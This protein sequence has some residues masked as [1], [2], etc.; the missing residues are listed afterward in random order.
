[1]KHTS[2]NWCKEEAFTSCPGQG[3]QPEEMRRLNGSGSSVHANSFDIAGTVSPARHTNNIIHYIVPVKALNI[4]A[5][6]NDPFL[7]YTRNR[8]EREHQS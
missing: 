4:Y 1:M 3:C 6:D 7:L 5:L 8:T 2:G